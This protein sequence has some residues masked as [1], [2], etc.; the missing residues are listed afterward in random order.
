MP[1]VPQLAKKFP[2]FYGTLRFV[3]TF[4]RAQHLSQFWA[5][6]MQSIPSQPVSLRSILILSS[7]LHL[8]TTLTATAMY[9]Q[10]Q[11]HINM[12]MF[13]LEISVVIS[14]VDCYWYFTV[15]RRLVHCSCMNLCCWEQETLI[16][17]LLYLSSWLTGCHCH[18]MGSLYLSVVQLNLAQLSQFHTFSDI[19]FMI[20]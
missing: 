2:A 3:T 9:L 20:S 11:Y 13:M 4:T 18:T 7:H 5:R 16:Y 19:F 12:L 6:S 1:V 15:W 14:F 8:G 17:E 10:F